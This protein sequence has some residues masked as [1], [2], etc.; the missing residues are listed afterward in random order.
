[1]QPTVITVKKDRSV[2]IALDARALNEAIDKDKY[3]LPNLENLMERVG[4]KTGTYHFL[5]SFY[6]LMVTPTEFQKVMDSLIA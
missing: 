3:Q 4:E 5:T 2:K 6:D 1:M